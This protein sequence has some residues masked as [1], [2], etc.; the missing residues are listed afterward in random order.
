MTGTVANLDI[1]FDADSFGGIKNPIG[2]PI[3]SSLFRP[4]RGA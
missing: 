4:R 1:L 3:S 2:A